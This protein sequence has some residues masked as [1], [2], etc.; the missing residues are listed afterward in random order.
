[1]GILRK[2]FVVGAVVLALPNPPASE[3]PEGVVPAT[4][5]TFAYL[6]AATETFA[7]FRSF[8]ERRPAVCQVAGQMAGNLELKARYGAK[9][10]YEWANAPAANAPTAAVP[11]DLANADPIATGTTVIKKQAE[12]QKPL[13]MQD[14]LSQ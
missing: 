1:M 4:T 10:A 12:P 6:A 13:T 9:L 8:C 5:S 2:A 11:S 7:D 14:L 3:Q